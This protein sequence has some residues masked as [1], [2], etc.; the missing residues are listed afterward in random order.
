MML[1]LPTALYPP[2]DNT[3]S[4]DGT[5]DIVFISVLKVYNNFWIT[6]KINKKK[7]KTKKYTFL[8]APQVDKIRI[9]K[10]SFEKIKIT[11]K[12]QENISFPPKTALADLQN[13]RG[14]HLMR[15]RCHTWFKC[16]NTCGSTGSSANTLTNF[17]IQIQGSESGFEGSGVPNRPR[18][19]RPSFYSEAQHLEMLKN[20]KRISRFSNQGA[21]I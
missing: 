3:F 4:E 14:R 20:T 11:I 7:N 1:L 5:L 13:I 16:T 2:G 6:W 15:E 10:S 19:L 8:I 17:W 21:K 9:H 12:S 18:N